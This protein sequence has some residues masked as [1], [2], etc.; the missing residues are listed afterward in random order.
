MYV[1]IYIYIYACTVPVEEQVD[2][3]AGVMQPDTYDTTRLPTLPRT[4]DILTY[5]STL[6][7]VVLCQAYTGLLTSTLQQERGAWHK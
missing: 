1:Y 4:Q 6:Y 3:S 5:L 7:R 2:Y